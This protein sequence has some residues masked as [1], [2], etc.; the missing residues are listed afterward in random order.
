M[1]YFTVPG[2]SLRFGC[3]LPH[4]EQKAFL[5]DAD[6]PNAS[7]YLDVLS[8]T[9]YTL[10]Y[11]IATIYNLEKLVPEQRGSLGEVACTFTAPRGGSLP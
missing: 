8:R 9:L 5:L 1:L 7:M 4:T 6:S 3:G 2:E 11:A 10:L